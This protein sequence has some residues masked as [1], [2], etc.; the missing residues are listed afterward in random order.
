METNWKSNFTTADL[1]ADRSF[2]TPFQI[3]PVGM[4]SNA[5]VDASLSWVKDGSVDSE[6]LDINEL[7]T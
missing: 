4:R 1:T 2:R 6:N 5:S 7:V 3:P